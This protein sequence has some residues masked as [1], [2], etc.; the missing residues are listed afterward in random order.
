MKRQRVDFTEEYIISKLASLGEDI[1]INNVILNVLKNIGTGYIVAGLFDVIVFEHRGI[2]IE[3]MGSYPVDSTHAGGFRYVPIDLRMKAALDN[4]ENLPVREITVTQYQPWDVD[5]LTGNPVLD[6][7]STKVR[8]LIDQFRLVFTNEEC[9]PYP[10][11]R[12]SSI[13]MELQINVQIAY[14]LLSL[15]NSI[16]SEAF[17]IQTGDATTPYVDVMFEIEEASGLL[18]SFVNTTYIPSSF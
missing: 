17:L 8:L 16:F 9:N 15:I 7:L 4:M 1:Y 2:Y 12:M 6:Q 14:T 5:S 18:L 10:V 13:E 11:E 3:E